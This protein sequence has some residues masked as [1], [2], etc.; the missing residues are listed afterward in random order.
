MV[1]AVDP[2]TLTRLGPK[3]I[4]KNLFRERCVLGIH[5]CE[6]L[7]VPGTLLECSQHY[8]EFGPVTVKF[9]PLILSALI[10][11]FLNLVQYLKSGLLTEHYGTRRQLQRFNR[12]LFRVA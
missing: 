11:E 5:S 8:G 10:I 7:L 4:I 2:Y 3:T 12:S 6:S 9:V 1:P